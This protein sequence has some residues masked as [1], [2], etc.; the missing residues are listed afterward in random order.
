MPQPDDRLRIHSDT[1][2]CFFTL[3]NTALILETP[4]NKLRLIGGTVGGG[5]GGKVDVIVEP[6]ACIAAMATGR[7]VKYVQRTPREEMQVS[8]PRG[9]AHLHQGRRHGRR[10]DRGSQ[11]DAL[12]GRRRVLAPQPLRHDQGRRAHARAVHDSQRL[13][14]QALPFTNRAPSSAM[15][16][17]RDHHADFALESQIDR[18][19]RA[20]GMD[21]LE[22]RLGSAIAMET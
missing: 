4:F 3:D 8:S 16:G 20:L 6:I 19:A 12:R 9:R 15:R 1:Q 22:L 17:A 13:G 11:G 7:P 2:A 21:P 18:I 10:H 14:R 5:F